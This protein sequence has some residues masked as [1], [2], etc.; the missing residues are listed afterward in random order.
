MWVSV[1]VRSQPR[2]WFLSSCPLC[3]LRQGLPL[4]WSMLLRL[5]WLASELYG[6]ACL[7]L[8]SA[9]ITSTYKHNCMLLS[10]VF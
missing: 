5:V 10:A 6:V 8:P 7:F 4:A 1:E 3:F 2:V 9:V